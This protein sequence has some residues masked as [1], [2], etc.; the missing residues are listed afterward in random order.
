[1]L[2]YWGTRAELADVLALARA[3]HIVASVECFD[4]ADAKVAYER[5]AAGSVIGRAVV[6]V[7][8]QSVG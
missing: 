1:V 5:L 4:L 2:S 6:G 8:N 7:T 3:G